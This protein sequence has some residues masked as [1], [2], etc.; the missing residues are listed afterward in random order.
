KYTLVA[1]LSV[2]LTALVVI[3]LFMIRRLKRNSTKA[4][5]SRLASSLRSEKLK[6]GIILNAIEDGVVLVDNQQM[7]QLFNPGAAKITGCTSEDASGLNWQAVFKLVTPK[8]EPIQDGQDP[9]RRL[10]NGQGTIRDDNA[11]LLTKSGKTIALSLVVSPILDEQKQV[12]G[13]VAV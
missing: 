7:I 3:L 11:N 9:V 13:A 5:D 8:G 4:T 10:F 1:V 12:T 2:A 6:S